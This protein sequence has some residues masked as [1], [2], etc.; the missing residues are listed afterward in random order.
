M[1]HCRAANAQVLLWL[2]SRCS[3]GATQ[4][5]E[6]RLLL[7]NSSCLQPAAISSISK[8]APLYFLL[9]GIYV[10][11]A[12]CLS[13]LVSMGIHFPPALSRVSSS[14]Q[15][16]FQRAFRLL[17]LAR[18]PPPA[19]VHSLVVRAPDGVARTHR[20]ATESVEIPAQVGERVT[21][22][23]AAPTTARGPGLGPLRGS[24][25]TPGWQP[26][27]P[28]ALTNHATGRVNKLL[29]APA[30]EGAGAARGL[31]LLVP[32]AVLLAGGDAATGFISPDLPGVVALGFAGTVVAGGLAR[33]YLLPRLNQVRGGG[34]AFPKVLQ[35]S[36]V[37]WVCRRRAPASCWHLCHDDPGC[38]DH[39]TRG[40][41]RATYEHHSKE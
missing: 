30:K 1:G 17:R 27:E 32:A 21:V 41:D 26:G 8:V 5:C 31:S 9:C 7:S 11:P 2:R 10:L 19:A 24:T 12:L 16:L 34:G 22:S 38:A 33:S 3:E 23:S 14:D 15:S 37:P 25:R 36:S 28:M 40:I 13:S 20:F 35:R 6:E 39:L 18:S 4:S 29:R